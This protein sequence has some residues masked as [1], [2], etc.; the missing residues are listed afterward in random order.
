MSRYIVAFSCPYFVSEHLIRRLV[1]KPNTTVGSVD[2]LSPREKPQECEHGV[3]D[4]RGLPS[5]VVENNVERIYNFVAIHTFRKMYFPK[6]RTFEVPL[7]AV[8]FCAK[9]LPTLDTLTSTF[10]PAASIS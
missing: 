6:V 10:I 1:K 9:V 7:W 8:F 2:F 5:F 4:V 3:G